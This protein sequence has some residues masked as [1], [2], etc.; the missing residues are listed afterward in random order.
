VKCFDGKLF[1]NHHLTFTELVTTPF[2][3]RLDFQ[4]ETRLGCRV[5]QLPVNGPALTG[6]HTCYLERMMR[7]YL[8]IGFFAFSLAAQAQTVITNGTVYTQNFNS[9]SAGLPQ[10]WSVRTGATTTTLGTAV[11]TLPAVA[12]WGNGTGAFRNFASSDGL[13]STTTTALQAAA[14]NRALGVQQSSGFGDPGASFNFNFSTSNATI[15]EIKLDV[16]MLSV[17]ARSTTWTLQYGLGANPPN[18]TT[19]AAPFGTWADPGAFGSTTFTLNDP[20]DMAAISNQDNV[21][22]RVAALT[23]ST[24]AG[25]RDSMGIDNFSMTPVPEPGTIFAIGAAVLGAGAVARRK[26]GMIPAA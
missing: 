23:A 3:A 17:Q 25:A 24:G 1:E 26:L 5:T 6:H 4:C 9:L 11:T 22:F 7:F 19:F 20:L 14:T 10:D 12:S 21:W 16:Q 8:F 18:W 13:P 2:I 15:D